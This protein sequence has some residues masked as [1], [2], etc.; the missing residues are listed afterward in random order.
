[1][2]RLLFH[3]KKVHTSKLQLINTRNWIH[4]VVSHF[5]NFQFHFR[6]KEM[7]AS[8]NEH[9]KIL[10][11]LDEAQQQDFVARQK[12]DCFEEEEEV[13]EGVLNPEMSI[14][15]QWNYGR[16]EK[17]NIRKM[18][19]FQA[20]F[21][22][23]AEKEGIPMETIVLEFGDDSKRITSTDTPDD[24]GITI[25]DIITGYSL[26]EK[27]KMQTGSAGNSNLIEIKVQMVDRRAN[28][29]SFHIK[30]DEKLAK[31]YSLIAEKIEVERDKVKLH[32]DGDVVE[33]DQT[34]EDLDLDGGE[35]MDCTIIS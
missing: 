4:L 15:I 17:H 24:T 9:N 30:P 33:M 3:Y 2:A 11:Y 18:Q 1:M 5:N 7:D 31:L 22:A 19:T 34:A 25:A 26:K 35:V 6:L 32:F 16:V 23:I 12:A 21:R 13:S 20:I 28:K 8:F 27:V 14:K 29:L 10:S